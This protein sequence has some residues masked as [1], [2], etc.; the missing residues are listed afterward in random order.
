MTDCAFCHRQITKKHETGAYDDQH[1]VCWIEWNER[2]KSGDCERCGKIFATQGN[3]CSN[4]YD[5][6]YAYSGYE[7]PQ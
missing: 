6:D 7:G 1:K 4:C 2:I 5:H 3:K